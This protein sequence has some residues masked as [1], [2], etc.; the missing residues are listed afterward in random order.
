MFRYQFVY[1]LFDGIR[2]FCRVGAEFL[3]NLG[4]HRI[5]YML[6][7]PQFPG[8]AVHKA[9]DVHHHI[10]EDFYVLF[11]CLYID[12]GNRRILDLV[13]KL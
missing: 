10:G 12:I 8:I 1:I 9:S 5:I 7:N 4:K 2:Q 3:N 13:C 6:C 11:F